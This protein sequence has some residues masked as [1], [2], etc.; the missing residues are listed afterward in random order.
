MP[1]IKIKVRDKC[2]EGDGVIICNNSDYTVVW[3]LDGEWTPYDTK[4]MRVNL[5]DGTY[6]DV[7]FTGDTA[8]LPV[9][10]ASGWV[11]VGLYAGDIH[12]SRAARLLAL[13]SVLTPGGS[14]A[15]PAED[16]Y[17]QIMAKLNELS[18]VSPEDIAKA[19][20]AYLT[21]LPAASAS[22][23]VEGGYIQFSSDGKTWENVIAL[24]NIRGAPGKDGAPGD[25]GITPH[26]GDN[27]NWY[28]GDTDTGK[29]SRGAPG[30]KG[31]P[32]K[33][34]AGM[35]ITGATVGQIAKI[36]AVDAEGRPTAWETIDGYT[37]QVT[38]D[39]LT[40]PDHPTD[41]VQY[42]AFQAAV[43]MVQQMG[44]FGATVGQIIKVKAVNSDG[45]PTAWEPVDMPAGGGED[46]WELINTISITEPVHAIDITIDS[47]GDAFS[48]KKIFIY[49]PLGLKADGNSQV[50]I[51]LYSGASTAM[52]FS[53]MND[54]IE[55]SPKALFAEFDVVGSFYREYLLASTYHLEDVMSQNVGL[56]LSK[57]KGPITRISISL[58]YNYVF[59]NGEFQIY[60]VRE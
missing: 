13:S 45:C 29:P 55:K 40:N 42:A 53:S 46:E 1:E 2:A 60:G 54:A 56:M 48:L 16:V 10:T 9:L 8:T 22:M 21:E 19:V 30:A 6:Q 15:A 31:D 38:V 57:N 50:F 27:G 37:G 18:T 39:N 32:G 25:D 59:T 52:Y 17:A 33:D 11:S 14:P 35:D 24:A 3:D 28:L 7:V 12:T 26:I 47:N 51:E 20:E 5:A 34:G 4:T 49:S 58:Q 44:I 36:S 41:L 23:R 43:P